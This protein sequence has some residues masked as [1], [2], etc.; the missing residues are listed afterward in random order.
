VETF[1][2]KMENRNREILLGL[3]AKRI[4]I[5]PSSLFIFSR[6]KEI[7]KL[8]AQGVYELIYYNTKEISNIRIFSSRMVNKIKNKK[9]L[10]LYKKSCLVI[11]AFND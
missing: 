3:R 9:T 8:L 11:Q 2:I 5:T 1:L 4:I 10:I 6:K 7:N